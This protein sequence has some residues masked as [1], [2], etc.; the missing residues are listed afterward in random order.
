MPVMPL[1][2]VSRI[3]GRRA[4]QVADGITTEIYVET[5]RPAPG[6]RGH[7]TFHLKHEISHLE[8]LS[9]LFEK[10]DAQELAGWVADEPTGQYARRAGFL[11]EFLTGRQLVTGVEIGGPYIDAIDEHRLVAASRGREVPNRR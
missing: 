10:C 6:L 11:Y 8:L 2:V 7:L 4:T 5:M 9:R 3:G 1:S